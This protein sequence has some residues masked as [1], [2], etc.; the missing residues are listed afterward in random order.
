MLGG[1]FLDDLEQKMK[2]GILKIE[3]Q[4]SDG[5]FCAVFGIRCAEPQQGAE[6]ASTLPPT[7]SGCNVHMSQLY[8]PVPR[9]HG[10]DKDAPLHVGL[11]GFSVQIGV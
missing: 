2:G 6:G 8:L 10:A 11:W 7:G 5:V 1:R 4:I 9:L 3:E